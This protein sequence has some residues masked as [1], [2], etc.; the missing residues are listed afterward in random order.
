M[1]DSMTRK[2][3]TKAGSR[4]W[5]MHVFYNML[6]ICGINSWILYKQCTE[7]N[8]SRRD[9][10]LLLG[11]QLCDIL[12]EQKSE[13]TIITAETATNSI[14]KRKQCQVGNHKNRTSFICDVCKKACYGPC[15]SI[16]VTKI[17]CTKCVPQ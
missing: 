3:T 10:L 5:P 2:Y 14:Q 12:V 16:K 8:I 17:T 1:Y 15:T 6:D 13:K 9:F 4:R 11:E 7:Q